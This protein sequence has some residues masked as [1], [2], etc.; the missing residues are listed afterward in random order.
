[1]SES[2][3]K[4]FKLKFSS[5]QILLVIIAALLFIPF[6]GAVH[7]FDWDEINFAE[8]SRE[9]ILSH[10][11]LQ[12]QIDFHS[13]FEKP[14]FFLW[15]QVLSYKIWGI[16]EFSARF[17]N[18][19]FGIFSMLFI[20]SL[21]LKNYSK[22]IA[23]WWVVLYMGSFLPHFYFRTGIID[24]VF[25]FFIYSA[26]LTFFFNYDKKNWKNILFSG[27]LIGLAVLTKGPVAILIAGSTILLFAIFKKKLSPIFLK[28]AF[29]FGV[30][31]IITFSIWFLLDY[32]QNGPVFLIEFIRYQI[33]LFSTEDAGHGGFF[34]Y[35]IIVLLFGCF[36]AS[37][38]ALK[39]FRKRSDNNSTINDFLLFNKILFFVV[40]ILFTIVKSKIVHYSSLCYF[41]LSLL[42]AFQIHKYYTGQEKENRF[43]YFSYLFIGIFLAI[44]FLFLANV[45][46]FPELLNNLTSKDIFARHIITKDSPWKWFD[47]LPSL[48][49]LTTVIIYAFS[50]QNK[51]AK[52]KYS[53]LLM[54]IAVGATIYIFPARI[55]YY[56][57]K[58]LIQFIEKTTAKGQPVYPVN[59]KSYAHLFYGNKNN[60]QFIKA[61]NQ[62]ILDME[63]NHD[64][65][66]FTRIDRPIDVH[67]YSNIVELN[68]LS[69]YIYYIKKAT[70][71]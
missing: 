49:V 11:F 36:P 66:L 17:P 26:L 68:R 47:I 63:L 33:R 61:S 58:D 57:Q 54:I 69:G 67:K 28:N 52:Y 42:G 7:L 43:T 13:F 21:A 39:G 50:N 4:F 35:H 34:G 59:H 9:M 46:K 6:L 10:N 62:S 29:L 18:A 24:P 64:I 60:N 40:L 22:E 2:E 45:T 65:Y 12:V 44:V 70:T 14:P 1:M 30:T 71:D 8:S 55:E 23:R 25:N 15:L 19:L 16:N 31:G 27:V 41:P 38:F 48:L 3:K 51:K 53:S 37:V 56:T 32:I 20:Y 5:D